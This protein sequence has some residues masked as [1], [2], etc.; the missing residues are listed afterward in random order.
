VNAPGRYQ[1][2]R[3]VAHLAPST[4]DSAAF[5]NVAYLQQRRLFA[6]QPVIEK[7]SQ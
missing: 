1:V 6:A 7:H 2:Q 3:Q 4:A 5:L